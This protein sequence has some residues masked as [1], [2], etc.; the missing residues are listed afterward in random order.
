MSNSKDKRIKKLKKKRIWPSIAGLFFITLIFGIILVAQLGINILNVTQ[1]KVATGVGQTEVIAK[2]FEEY[3]GENQQM[4]QDSV[5]NY[6]DI[7]PEVEAVW[8]SDLDDNTVWANSDMMPNVEN[9]AVLSFDGEQ[10]ISL[11]LEENFEQGITIRD[12]EIVFNENLFSE[13]DISEVLE[14][15]FYYEDEMKIMQIKAWYLQEVGDLKV[16]VLQNINIYVYDILTLLT[17]TALFGVMIAI[18]IMYYL[19]SF[20]SVIV[21]MRK[22]T[23]V[24]YTDMVT[25]GNNWLYFVKR[26]NKLLKKKSASNNY[27]VIHLKM[28]KYRSFCT[29]FGVQEGEELIEKMYQVL[30]KQVKRSEVMAYKQ[31]AEFGLVLSYTD[32]RQLCDRI[33]MLTSNLDAILPKMKLYF[34]AGIYKVE[35]KDKDIE[36]LYNNAMLACDMLGEEAEN[37][38][39]FFDVEMNKRRLW[40]RKVED[41]MDA[42]LVNHEFQVYLQPKI[43]TAQESLAGAEALVRWIHPQEGFIPPNRFIPIFER[44]GFIL[45]LD[46]YMLEEIAKQQAQWISQGR[47]VVPISVNVSRAHFAKEDLAEHICS[48]VDKYQVPHSVIELELTESAFFDDKEVLL[49]TVKKLREAGFPVSMDDFGAGYSSLNSL[50]ELQLD[51]LKLDADFFRGADAQERG[52]LIV[53]EVIDLAKKLNMKIVAEGIESREQVDFLTEQEC[54]LIQGYFFAKPM[55]ISEFEEKYKEM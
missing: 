33:E 31:N 24:I 39:V 55:P 43:S 48:I 51:V 8:V 23:K 13:V 17:N 49:Q 44:N 14:D 40:E 2:L 15:G 11:I 20:I 7:T 46:D 18:F 29:C 37:K 34:A 52:L 47:K 9:V 53:S 25:G 30:K 21:S 35:K 54:D 19:I 32:D 38:I 5:S 3:E 27:A 36:Q 12:N 1:N 50:K 41:D 45:K 10:S 42:A 28:R 4:I 16:Y 26:G 22:T 6:V